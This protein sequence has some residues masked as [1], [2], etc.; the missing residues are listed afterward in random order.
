MANNEIKLTVTVNY[1][2]FSFRK[3]WFGRLI[4]TRR[5][6]EHLCADSGGH[7]HSEFVW[8]DATVADLKDYYLVQPQKETPCTSP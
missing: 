4:L 7:G 3:G 2:D 8:R 5:H 1:K 6:E